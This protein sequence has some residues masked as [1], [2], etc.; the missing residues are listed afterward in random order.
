MNKLKNNIH[1]LFIIGV[2][3]SSVLFTG[4]HY[5]KVEDNSINIATTKEKS[6]NKENSQEDDNNNNNKVI[7]TTS[8]QSIKPEDIEVAKVK[9]VKMGPKTKKKL[10]KEEKKSEVASTNYDISNKKENYIP[11]TFSIT[12]YTETDGENGGWG[13]MVANNKKIAPGMVAG[14]S[15]SQF[16]QR[17]C[18]PS[19]GQHIAGLEG[20]Q[21]FV[22]EDLM[23]EHEY[24]KGDNRI[25]VYVPKLPGES[26]S[27]YENRVNSYGRYQVQGYLIQ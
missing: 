24:A 4:V 22:I 5:N 27:A 10:G 13:G 25:D 21:E 16:G 19:F 12:F 7:T 26:E 6:K 23:A 3:A 14:G 11:T 2:I 18:I 9:K 15:R 1:I 17:I 8:V 20:I